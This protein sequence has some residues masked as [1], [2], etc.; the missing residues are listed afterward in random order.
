VESNDIDGASTPPVIK[1]VLQPADSDSETPQPGSTVAIAY[2][3]SLW[4][5]T[6]DDENFGRGCGIASWDTETVLDCWLKEQQGLF[7]PLQGPFAEH[8]VDGAMLLDEELFTEEF[9]SNTLGVS[10]K[11]QCKKTIMAA[12][13]LRTTVADSSHAQVFD[14]KSAE[15]PYTFVLGTGKTIRAMELLVAS[16]AVGET[17]EVVARCD[18]GYGADGFRTSKGDVLVPPFCGLSFQVTLLSVDQE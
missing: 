10:N 9:V 18:Y 1:R 16:M 15:A 3:G 2:S 8:S 4:M 12:R 13:R 7:E 11:I 5:D 6:S 14:S 17:S